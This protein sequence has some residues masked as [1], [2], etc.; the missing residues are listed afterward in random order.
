MSS[1]YNKKNKTI[2][3]P[4]DW[5]GV[6]RCM[7]GAFFIAPWYFMQAG[8]GFF[9][10]SRP[11]LIPFLNS[12]VHTKLNYYLLACGLIWIGMFLISYHIRKTQTENKK[13]ELVTVILPVPLVFAIVITHGILM[14][15]VLAGL[16]AVSMLGFFL[17][18]TR[19]MVISVLFNA[20][21]VVIVSL[22]SFMEVIPFT[23][24]YKE[25]YMGTGARWW[26][27]GQIAITMY[28]LLCGIIMTKFFLKGLREREDKIRELSR[29]DGL[30]DIW[31]R[32]Y[33]ME[34]FER[35]LLLSKRADT[36]ISFI[37][38]DLD[39]FKKLNDEHGHKMGDKAL[40][41]A[42]QVLQSAL[43]N[44]DY[45]GR[46]GGEEFAAILPNCNV[47]AAREVAE[48]CRQAIESTIV[49]YNGVEINLTTSVGVTTVIK[50]ANVSADTIIERADKA[51]YRSKGEGRNKVSIHNEPVIMNLVGS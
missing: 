49:T 48:R 39:H 8:F 9:L 5:C 17:F 33:L 40:E 28:P 15:S 20:A 46:Y 3:N 27:G 30:T 37:M 14:S 35:E 1:I 45:L 42:A 7:L 24:L 6:D 26:M 25:V 31:N 16:V 11:D 36:P 43:R 12:E 10:T 51:L 21:L 18:E 44:T 4:I 34:I 23:S 50:S 38:I 29:K 32:R 13:L 22:L 2:V 19:L 47:G 41:V